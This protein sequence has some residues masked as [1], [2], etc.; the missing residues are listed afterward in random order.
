MLTKR[1]LELRETEM[2]QCWNVGRTL[3]LIAIRVEDYGIDVPYS[4]I[5]GEVQLVQDI[6]TH[7]LFTRRLNGSSLTIVKEFQKINWDFWTRVQ[8]IT[9]E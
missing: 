4:I 9:C 2:N 6:V 3:R 5:L 8:E 7:A 1:D